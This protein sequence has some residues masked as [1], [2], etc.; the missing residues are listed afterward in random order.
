MSSVGVES[1]RTAPTF[2]K[3]G[4]GPGWRSPILTASASDQRKGV[5]RTVAIKAASR[6]DTTASEDVR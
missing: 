2:C 1:K 5:R 3:S 6:N 4:G